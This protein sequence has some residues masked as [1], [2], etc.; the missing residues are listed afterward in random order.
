MAD[1]AL[2]SR[3]RAELALDDAT[4]HLEFEVHAKEG[5]VRV[6][7]A[8]SN[9]REVGEIRRVATGVPGVAALNLNELASPVRA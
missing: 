1:L 4:S 3:V 5:S 9:M 6:R 7:G 2:A 8:L